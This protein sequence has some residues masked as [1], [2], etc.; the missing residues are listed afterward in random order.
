MTEQPLS[1]IAE[2]RRLKTLI[3]EVSASLRSQREILKMRGMSL[4]PMVMRTLTDIENDI[5]RLESS[6]VE[7]QTEL[8]Q[9]RALAENYAM[10]T[11]S[12]DMDL[13][14]NQ[15]MDVVI[16][17]TGA[18]RGY[19]ALKDPETGELNFRVQR[20]SELVP[21][22]GGSGA[23]QISYTILNEVLETGESL[24][25]D[26]AYK[27]E[28]LQNNVS[29]AQ[30]TLRS[31]LCVPLVYKE[32]VIGAVY[33]DNR[34][35]SGVFEQ[36][37]KTLLSA[38]ANQASVAFENAR[39][40]MDIQ[41]SLAEIT[42][43]KE[44]MDNVFASIGSGVITADIQHLVRQVNRAAAG[45]LEFDET[46]TINQK[47]STILPGVSADLDAHLATVREQNTSQV[48]EAEMETPSRGRIAVSIKLSPLKGTQGVAVV[49]DDLTEQRERE[50]M[51]TIVKRYLPP[52]MVDNIQA[53]SQLGLG[54][55]RRE[56]TCAFVEVLSPSTFPRDARPQ[57]IVETVNI[58]LSR[59]TACIHSTKGIIDKYMGN[60]IMSLFNTQLNPMDDHA[61]RAI[62]TAL[63][64]REAFIKLYA[65]LGINPD[66]HYYRIGMH[67]GIATLGNV[68]SLNRR[69]FSAIG[70]TINLSKRLE[71]NATAGQIIISE[72][73][74][75]HV[76]KHMGS[77]AF[78]FHFSDPR[79]M[80]VKGREQAILVYEVF[81]S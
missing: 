48:L 11:S 29:I 60:E 57:Q 27:D 76:Q 62:E 81:K 73:T 4:P 67:T 24:L 65:E 16:N 32:K 63:N 78:P 64:I 1:A 45:I 71:E 31:V 17:L 61:L 36:R 30:L 26:N 3:G 72:D 58:Y 15:A 44:L 68:G 74:Y 77:A 21:R 66:P 59:A 55:E 13:V 56:V 14:L 22:Q 51:L 49:L 52:E 75:N 5:T 7:D 40:Y 34:L 43:V 18:E 80:K 69:E 39:L 12:L 2:L 33:V 41:R 38:F 10:I 47:L 35:R 23:P 37:E 54:G 79:P 28:R 70:D 53:I 6:V 9:L 8:G 42:E 19:I 25:A 46:Q 50:E 20:E